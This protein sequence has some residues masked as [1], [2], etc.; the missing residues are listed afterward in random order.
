MANSFICRPGLA[1][2]QWAG[3][4]PIDHESALTEKP[5]TV[6]FDE[7]VEI[8]DRGD[9]QA[10]RRPLPPDV[11]RQAVSHPR[12]ASTVEHRGALTVEMHGGHVG[13]ELVEHRGKRGPPPNVL[14]RRRAAA[15]HIS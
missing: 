3:F 12:S 6:L 7:R 13:V 4:G 1:G 10:A 15:V 9:H 14:G 8:A 5:S 11:M 2:A